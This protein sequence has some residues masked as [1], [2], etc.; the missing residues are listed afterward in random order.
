MANQRPSAK[1]I[2]TGHYLPEKVVTNFDL[3]K[4]MDTSD[5]WIRQRSGIVERRYVEKGQTASDLAYEASKMAVKNA[6]LK[7]ENIDMILVATLTPEHYFPGTCSYLQHKL[8]LETTPSMGIRGQCTG[9]LYAMSIAK[10][11]VESGMYQNVLVCGVEVH[12]NA[13]DFSTRGRDVAVLFGDGAGACVV[14][15]SDQ[16]E[17]GIRN[18]SLHSQGEHAEK[19]WMKYPTTVEAPM[20]PANGYEEG[21]AYPKM[22]GR[23]VFKN[24]VVRMPQ[25]LKESLESVSVTLDDISLFLFHQANLRINEHICESLKIPKEKAYNN[26]EKYGNCSAASI[27]I[28]LSECVEQDRL[29]SG[30]LICM[31]GFGSG[32]TW[33]SAVIRW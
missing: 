22:D 16:A 23:F 3:E 10:A 26:I 1:I 27:P 18:V 14:S 24:A 8:G 9:Y 20:M 29:R 31:T 4:L 21:I 13:L 2:G 33:G 15:A 17:T 11:Y 28:C 7:P 32:F 6:D 5:E 25:V 30:D 19:L 12:S